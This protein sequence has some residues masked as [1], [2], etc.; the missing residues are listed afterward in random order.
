MRN[1]HEELGQTEAAGL[2]RRLL[3]VS[4]PSG[5]EV[6]VAG[7]RML[8]LAS[9]DYLGLCAHPRI[10]QAMQRA[11]EAWG[12]G[13]GA[14]RLISGTSCLDDS[15]EEQLARFKGSEAALLF[16]T[17]YMAN[18]GLLAALAGPGD[19]VYS[20]EL[21]HAS[22]VD[23]CRLSR[24]QVRVYPHA[25]LAALEALLQQDRCSQAKL[26]VSDAVFSMDGDIAPLAGLVALARA[27]GALLVIDDAHGT[28]VLGRRGSGALEHCGLHPDGN[29]AIMGTLGKALGAFG[30]FVAGSALLKD[31]LVNRARSFIFTTALPPPVLAAAGEAVRIIEEEPERRQ[32]LQEQAA[33]MRRSLQEL[34][35]NTLN[36]ATQ[37][38]PIV[39]GDSQVAVRIAADLFEKN[40]FIRAIRPPAVPQG[41]ARLRV[42]VMATHTRTQLQGALDALQCS[43]RRWGLI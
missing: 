34:G 29:M 7:R 21:N 32:R 26:I 10:I 40:I 42:S 31:Y 8:M 28:G 24:A 25:D 36:S 9:N 30:A 17:G 12:A 39:I 35:L 6:V 43:A 22:I 16:S 41:S 18:L 15:L 13:A 1:L 2:Y 38:I 4:S 27:H 14:S 11:A 5:P 33:F 3:T 37:I 19:T 20:D 23:G